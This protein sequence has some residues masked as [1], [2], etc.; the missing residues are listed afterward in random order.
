MLDALDKRGFSQLSQDGEFDLVVCR[1]VHFDAALLDK[2]SKDES[3]L[4]EILSKRVW[5]NV[6]SVL[7]DTGFAH[8]GYSISR[9]PMPGLLGEACLKMLTR[10]E[11]QG[12]A[13]YAD[14]PIARLYFRPT[15]PV[16]EFFIA[17]KLEAGLKEIVIASK[18]ENG[19]PYYSM[20]F[21]EYL[22]DL[23][24]LAR[25]FGY[26]EIILDSLMLFYFDNGITDDEKYIFNYWMNTVED[27]RGA[28]AGLMIELLI[29]ASRY[30]TDEGL[31]GLYNK[32][33]D[34]G[35]GRYIIEDKESMTTQVSLLE[36][37]IMFRVGKAGI[38]QWLRDKIINF[39]L[40]PIEQ[41]PARVINM[42]I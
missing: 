38:P 7:K 29:R 41:A 24:V 20:E 21:A 6:A 39:D 19:G 35:I 14:Y 26:R 12:D 28:F 36:L 16:R 3:L 37:D 22:G 1:N 9:V 15:I 34:L 2:V 13:S 4:Q 18:D 10:E 11:M 31:Q 8:M 40:T 42:S 23:S 30:L 33:I 5:Q 27:K 32:L 17:A 25:A